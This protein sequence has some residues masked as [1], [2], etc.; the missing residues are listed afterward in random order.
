MNMPVEPAPS[1]EPAGEPVAPEPA[2]D[3]TTIGVA[4]LHALRRSAAESAKL[5][6]SA[7]ELAEGATRERDT[8]LAENQRIK[9]DQRV[10]SIAHRM[11]F[12]DPVDVLGRI[13]PEEGESDAGVRAALARIAQSSPHLVDMPTAVPVIGQVLAPAAVEA[14][15]ESGGGPGTQ[16]TPEQIRQ[17][18]AA[19]FARMDRAQFA[20]VQRVLAQ[21]G[22]APAA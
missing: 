21:M 18:S 22:P 7:R 4:E 20:S 17:M 8:V 14:A 9:R 15:N 3:T 12:R 5:S 19:D 10:I 16:F 2:P 1:V 6:R 11:R 13:T